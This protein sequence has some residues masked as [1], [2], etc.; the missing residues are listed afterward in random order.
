MPIK[1]FPAEIRFA[2]LVQNGVTYTFE[3]SANIWKSLFF[4]KCWGEMP[5]LNRRLSKIHRSPSFL[6]EDRRIGFRLADVDTIFF[7]S[8]YINFSRLCRYL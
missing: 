4:I 3:L 7:Q 6:W 5:W 2:R 1:L 8:R